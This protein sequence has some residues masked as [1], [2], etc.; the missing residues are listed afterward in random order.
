MIE[1]GMR[2]R[3]IADYTGYAQMRGGGAAGRMATVRVVYPPGNAMEVEIDDGGGWAYM[4]SFNV[5]LLG[6][7]ECLAEVGDD[8]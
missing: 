1:V 5:T 7:L 2:V 3:I 6:A 4:A 8:I